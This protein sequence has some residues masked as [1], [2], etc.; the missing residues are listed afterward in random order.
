MDKSPEYPEF[1]LDKLYCTDFLTVF[2]SSC[3][4]VSRYQCP[5]D[6]TAS[7]CDRVS[8]YQESTKI[9]ITLYTYI[10]DSALKLS[11]CLRTTFFGQI[12]CKMKV[13]AYEIQRERE[14]Y[15]GIQISATKCFGSNYMYIE[16]CYE[17]L[18]ENSKP[19][20]MYIYTL[21]WAK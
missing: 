8:K 3:V 7:I 10:D 6:N 15:T 21:Y 13:N 14:N 11:D 20:H 9:V 18:R 17:S 2:T 4:S 16:T 1:R 19:M 5:T 12:S